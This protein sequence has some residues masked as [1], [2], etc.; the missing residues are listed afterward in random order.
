[1]QRQRMISEE[2]YSKLEKETVPWIGRPEE[3][4]Q[5]SRWP[6]VTIVIVFSNFY[7][8]RVSQNNSRY[9]TKSNH[10]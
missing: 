5:T 8:V 4:T 7:H 10:I 1:M 3:A 2:K 6:E 9:C